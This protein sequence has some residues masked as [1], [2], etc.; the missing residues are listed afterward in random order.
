MELMRNYFS[1]LISIVRFHEVA[2]EGK[3][4]I[5]GVSQA[6]KRHHFP[7]SV[8]YYHPS[9]PLSSLFGRKNKQTRQSFTCLS[10]SCL[11]ET[12]H[13]LGIWCY[14][15]WFLFCR[16]KLCMHCNP[17]LWEW[18]LCLPGGRGLGFFLYSREKKLGFGRLRFFFFYSPLLLL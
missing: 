6:K 15:L 9:I 4:K 8:L 14:H 17:C 13:V 5:S 10:I 11:R 18:L 7:H 2:I 3:F 1:F 12:C 16:S